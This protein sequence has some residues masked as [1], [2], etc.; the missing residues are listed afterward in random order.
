MAT[1][2]RNDTDAELTALQVV[3]PEEG[4]DAWKRA[5]IEQ[6]RQEEDAGDFATDDEVRDLFRR[7]SDVERAILNLS[8]A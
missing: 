4:Y 6:A 3:E 5:E 7:W 1:P 2:Q 8:N